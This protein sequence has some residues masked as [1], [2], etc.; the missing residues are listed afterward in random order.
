MN[1]VGVLYMPFGDF[2]Q[3]EKILVGVG[4]DDNPEGYPFEAS[5][6]KIPAPLF[7]PGHIFILYSISID[8][9]ARFVNGRAVTEGKFMAGMNGMGSMT[10]Q[11]PL[12][13][14][15]AEAPRG[16][17][18][19]R[20]APDPRALEAGYRSGNIQ[21]IISALPAEKPGRGDG[22]GR[23]TPKRSRRLKRWPSRAI[24]APFS[25]KENKEST[26]RRDVWRKNGGFDLSAILQNEENG[27]SSCGRWRGAWALSDKLEE[28]LKPAADVG[29][30]VFPPPGRAPS[31]PPSPPETGGQG[32]SGEP[33]GQLP[34]SPQMIAAVAKIAQAMK[35][36]GAGKPAFSRAS[37]PF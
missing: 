29:C 7:S 19:P 5:F 26:G 15:R 16:A 20:P 33:P 31:P 21:A 25:G 4:D 23:R 37:G 30:C 1:Q 32:K 22:G 24:W 3:R 9:R 14:N 27:C 18:A 28:V 11:P 36:G 12:G 34:L 35:P 17:G 2:A 10:P 13:G 6:L 8:H